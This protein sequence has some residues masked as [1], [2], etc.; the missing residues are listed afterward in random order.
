M[1]RRAV[2]RILAVRD[3]Q[4]PDALLVCLGAE[5]RHL[6]QLLALGEFARFFAELHDVLGQCRV[7]AGHVGEKRR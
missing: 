6:L 7:N 4:K 2:E 3:A 1:N 5:A